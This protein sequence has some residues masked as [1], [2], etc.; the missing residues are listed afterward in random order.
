MKKIIVI[1]ILIMGSSLYA[2]VKM[3]PFNG[4]ILTTDQFGFYYEVK[5]TEINKYAIN[6]KLNCSYSN[7]I[8]G[9]IASVDVS[10]PQKIVVYFKDFTKVLILDNTLS[11]TSEIIDLTRL[12]LD[13]TSLVCRSYNNGIWYYDPIRFELIRKDQELETTNS[14]GNLANALMINIQ[15]NYLVEYNNRLYL[16]DPKNGVLVFDNFVNK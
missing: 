2:Q 3:L 5:N 16:N 4:N 7:N 13:E 14:S 6:G 10:N 8:L 15:A 12:E 1:L 11:P 9:V